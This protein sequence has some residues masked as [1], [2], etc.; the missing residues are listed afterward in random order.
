MDERPAL[1]VTGGSRG[2]GAAT[3]ILAAGRG[4]DVALTFVDDA[5]SAGAVVAACEAVGADAFAM[6]A[7]SGVP[8]DVIEFFDAATGEVGPP[9]VLVNN[10]GTLEPAARLDEMT[11]VRLERVF[12]VNVIGAFVAAR[13]AVTRMSTR[14]GGTG[15]SIVSVSS[16]AAYLGSPNE[17]VDYAASKGAIDTMTI[18][19]AKEVAREG[20]RVN[21][22]RPGLIHTDIHQLTGIDDR[23][24]RLR[25]G[26]PMG[27]GGTAEEVAESILWLASDAAS[28]V[29][30]V[31]LNC[32]G[33]R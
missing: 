7:D 15:G 18:G 10:A 5:D 12:A 6:R 4:Y 19:L 17:F 8:A 23:I 22:V 27:R 11:A 32:S 21:A 31:L 14:H 30:G 29:T 24:G 28:Y 25:D 9:A 1:Y 13:E 20:I 33:G 26:V 3:A 16:A 2:I